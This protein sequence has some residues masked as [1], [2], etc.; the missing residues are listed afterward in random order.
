MWVYIGVRETHQE[1]RSEFIRLAPLDILNRKESKKHKQKR[2]G[3][4]HKK[5]SAQP[6]GGAT[7]T[8]SARRPKFG[9]VA[10][11]R[12]RLYVI[13]YSAPAFFFSCCLIFGSR[14]CNVRLCSYLQIRI[15]QSKR[16][17]W[18]MTGPCLLQ[19]RFFLCTLFPCA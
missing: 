17:A 13:C 6:C 19:S 3:E 18:Q 11:Y 9:V 10:V 8:R 2:S 15:W 12:T 4:S 5:R 16:Y 1:A 14:F 7:A